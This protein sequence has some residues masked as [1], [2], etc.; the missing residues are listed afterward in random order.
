MR[1]YEKTTQHPYC[2][3]LKSDE[4]IELLNE[5]SEAVHDAYRQG[6]ELPTL[7]KVHDRLNDLLKEKF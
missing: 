1:A 5:I 2:L 6:Q 7:A 3:Y 4:L